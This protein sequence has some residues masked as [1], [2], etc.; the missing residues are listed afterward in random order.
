MKLSEARNIA[1]TVVNMIQ[2][3]RITTAVTVAGSIRRER[4]DVND[5]EI[6]L[7]PVMEAPEN[8]FGQTVAIQPSANFVSTMAQKI[9]P[10]IAGE[11]VK[12]S[13]SGRYCRVK[14]KVGIEVDFFIIHHEYDYMRH[15]A[16]RTGNAN[17]A[18][19]ML[20]TSWVKM[21][22]C[23]TDSGLY[24]KN[25]CI[26]S[27][28]G[29]KVTFTPKPGAIPAGAWQTEQQFFEFLKINWVIPRMREWMG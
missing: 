26:R 12:G 25:D 19:K 13:F 6:V 14:L 3:Y 18:H 11:I 10:Q 27:K 22:Y 16:I 1:S 7:C 2:A 17:Y 28:S 29:D 20:A 9:L 15:V 24:K 5:V 21:G 23:A 4:P 8:L